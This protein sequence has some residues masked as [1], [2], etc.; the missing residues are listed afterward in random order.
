MTSDEQEEV[1]LVT[2]HL[3][4]VTVF[5]CKRIAPTDGKLKELRKGLRT[6]E[7]GGMR[8]VLAVI[9]GRFAR[10]IVEMSL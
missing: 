5:T 4:L 6:V 1:Y 8:G 10:K 2:L 9:S 7:R 3:S